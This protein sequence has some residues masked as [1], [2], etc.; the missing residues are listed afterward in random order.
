MARKV[1]T[2]LID[3]LDGSPLDDSGQT[4][5][6]ALEGAYYEIDLGPKN[7]DKLR[8]A[9]T[10][11]I[12]SARKAGR[13]GPTPSSASGTKHNKEELAAA[14]EWLRANGHQVADRGRIA[15]DLLDLY[16]SSK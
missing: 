9:L 8:S 14:R 13:R 11:F 3:D 6:F 15:G 2:T 16:R 10:P 7:A 4:I 1:T 12:D 5:S